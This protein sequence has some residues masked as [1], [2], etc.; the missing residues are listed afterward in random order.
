MSGII[1]GWNSQGVLPPIDPN[2]PVST[3]RS[4]YACSLAG[5]VLQFGT[6]AERLNILNGILSFRSSLHGAGLI[7]GFQWLD[8]SFLESIESLESRP[9][10]DIDVVTFYYLP[11]NNTQRM[12]LGAYPQLFDHSY[13]KTNYHVDAYFIDLMGSIPEGLISRSTYWYSLWSH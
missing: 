7:R 1:P 12:L 9:P 2:N 4:P 8:G 11:N 5:F 13:I 3:K 10:N 6:S